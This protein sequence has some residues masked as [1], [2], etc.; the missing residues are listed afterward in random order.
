MKA[1]FKGVIL[2]I[3]TEGKKLKLNFVMGGGGEGGGAE[4]GC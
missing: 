2:S 3:K 1:Y 4:G